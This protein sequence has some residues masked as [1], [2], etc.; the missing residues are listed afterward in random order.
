[1]RRRTVPAE[2]V[3]LL[4][5]GRR[6]V[7]SS[8]ALSRRRA[9]IAARAAFN[10]LLASYPS[11]SVESGRHSGLNRLSHVPC[12]F[13]RAPMKLG[14]WRRYVYPIGFRGPGTGGGAVKCSPAWWHLTVTH[15]VDATKLHSAW[16]WARSHRAGTFRQMVIAAGMSAD[17]GRRAPAQGG[18]R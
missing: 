10:R 2:L 12:P 13:C 9:R 15:G 8:G 11:A 17:L 5:A 6:L 14:P 4:S 18:A 1:M 16:S 7:E 3:E